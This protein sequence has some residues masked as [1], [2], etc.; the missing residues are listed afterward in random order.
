MDED[1]D[2]LGFGKVFFSALETMKMYAVVVI[3][4]MSVKIK[5]LKILL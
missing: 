1:G 2:L 5:K 3:L 4:F